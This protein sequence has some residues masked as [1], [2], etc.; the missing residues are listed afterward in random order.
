MTDPRVRARRDESRAWPR[1]RADAL[2]KRLKAGSGALRE[3]LLALVLQ[4]DA[5]RIGRGRGRRHF[6]DDVQERVELA[7]RAGRFGDHVSCPCS[8]RV[9]HA[10]APR[11]VEIRDAPAR[12]AGHRLQGQLVFRRERRAMRDAL[13]QPSLGLDDADDVAVRAV[14]RNAE[15]RLQMN[16]IAGKLLPP[17]VMGMG[18]HFFGRPREQRLA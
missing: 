15:K 6:H 8:D 16:L 7:F 5:A 2:P 14:N 12:H 1:I 11:Q 18:A 9:R 13:R 17:G 3:S 10:I 4:E